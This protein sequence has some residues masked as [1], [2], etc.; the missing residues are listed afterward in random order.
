ML[1]YWSS[2]SPFVRKVMLV[3]HEA[4]VADRISVERVVVG[5]S[6]LNSLVMRDNPLNKIPTVLLDDGEPLFDS[7][8]ICE[9]LDTIGRSPGL[10]P[11]GERRWGALRWQALG[12]GLMDVLVARLSEQ[13]RSEIARSQVHLDAYRTKCQATLDRF[14]RDADSLSERPVCIGAIAIACALSYIDF[15][16]A[17]DE[18]RARHPRLAA[19][20][21]S[22]RQRASMQATEFSN[23]Y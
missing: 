12:D 1:L 7:R 21:E 13:G 8:V 5:G 18:W 9:Y 2:R 11:A 20:F 15:R 3:A 6:K 4:G 19:W 22:F 23:E 17:A 10:F 14:E 16:F